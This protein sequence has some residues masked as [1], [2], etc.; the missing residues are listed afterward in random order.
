M[1][2]TLKSAVKMT[3]AKILFH[4]GVS[5]FMRRMSKNTLTIL[6]Y[7]SFANRKPDPIAC[8]LPAHEF[9]IQL[10]Y[11]KL[12]YDVVSLSNG[13]E[14]LHEGGC[15]DRNK[16]PLLS[17]TMDDGHTD[18]Y[19]VAY[20]I[21]EK[22]G[23]SA[24]VFI[25]TDFIDNRRT[26]WPS[27]LREIL[28][29]TDKVRVSWPLNLRLDSVFLKNAALKQ[30]KQYLGTHRP[31]IR[32]EFLD[33]MAVEL[34]VPSQSDI[35]PL[36]WHQLRTLRDHGWDIGSHTVYHS[37][38]P[39]FD[40]ASRREELL[41]S[42]KRIEEEIEK[43][44]LLFSYPDGSWDQYSKN[45]V[46]ETGYKAGVT[47]DWG[48]NINHD[49]LFLLKRIEVPYYEG[50]QTFACRVSRLIKPIPLMRNGRKNEF[51]RYF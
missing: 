7:H 3:V 44:C 9:E 46:L 19:D 48:T 45:S 35:S 6:T 23:L 30:L 17:I 16:R 15:G 38:L 10:K 18:N 47:Q 5:T 26:P 25:C 33:K 28:L 29:K 4:A 20:P 43:E 40:K 12:H 14:M 8:S 39:Y 21:L 42:K 31:D 49:A 22:H 27:R 34:N 51:L 41:V 1:N 36:T 2:S 13:L 32:C 11:L 37:M 50:L 24:T